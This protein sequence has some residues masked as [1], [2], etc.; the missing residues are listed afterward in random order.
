M[1]I[2]NIMNIKSITILVLIFS[3][4]LISCNHSTVKNDV[5][6]AKV[7][8][9]S[10]KYSEFNNRLKKA[11]NINS[12]IE[13]IKY[14]YGEIDAEED[15]DIEVERLDGNQ[16]KIQLVQQNIRDDSISGMM[17]VMFA[18]QEN[19]NWTVQDIQRTWKCQKGRGHSEFSSEPCL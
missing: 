18:S 3:I 15:I 8:T 2:K 9:E 17:V 14:Y 11:E 19:D 1:K 13:L 12:P 7:Q 16:Y 4:V 10:D 6:T 5:N